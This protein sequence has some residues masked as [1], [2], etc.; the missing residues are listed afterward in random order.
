MTWT[1]LVTYLKTPVHHACLQRLGVTPEQVV[2]P[3]WHG[4]LD[5]A[6]AVVATIPAL[7]LVP[8]DFS[9]R[10]LRDLMAAEL[11]PSTH[12]PRRLYVRRSSTGARRVRNE[13]ELR[14]LLE[15]LRFT[16]VDLESLSFSEQVRLFANADV[17]V[18]PHGAGLA[19]LAFCR[20][21][22]RVVELFARR[23]T[24]RCYQYLSAIAGLDYGCL[25][26]GGDRP[27]KSMGRYLPDDMTVD[28]VALAKVLRDL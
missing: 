27:R 10:F 8:S 21:G 1:R 15:D 22:T 4:Q 6:E 25:I 5:V 23:F 24:P 18:G 9:V 2:A 7:P 12:S 16:T 28:A 3:P 17:V 14:R 13:S 19:N 20:P 26:E 11:Q